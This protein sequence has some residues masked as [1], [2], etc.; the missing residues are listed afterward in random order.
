MR[1]LFKRKEVDHR[2]Q[3]RSKYNEKKYLEAEPHLLE[4]LESDPDDKW[5][6]DV[7][8]RLYYNTGRYVDSIITCKRL[9][10]IKE[11]DD[12]RKLIISA[13][14]RSEDWDVV[15]AETDAITWTKDDSVL[16]D[17]ILSDTPNMPWLEKFTER[18]YEEGC[19]DVPL[20][21]EL[22]SLKDKARYCHKSG[23]MANT[24]AFCDS[25]LELQESS[26]FATD[27]RLKAGMKIWEGEFFE[28]ELIKTIDNWPEQLGFRFMLIN[29]LLSGKNSPGE[30]LKVVSEAR[31]KWNDN[32]R[33]ICTEAICHSR[34][35]QHLQAQ[36]ICDEGMLLYPDD[37]EIL[38]ATAQVQ[39]GAGN[40]EKQL[41]Y[42]NSVLEKCSFEAIVSTS[43]EGEITPANL[44]CPSALNS[45]TETLVSIVMTTYK[46]DPLIKTAV[47]SILNQ[48]HTNLELIIV[49][50]C[51]PD[52]N[53]ENLKSLQKG[54][55]RII[56]HQMEENGGTYVA[57]NFGMTMA[58]GEY[59]GFMDSDDYCHPQRIEREV[60]VLKS[61]P[62]AKA[63]THDYF[64]IDENSNIEFR[65]KGALRM[66]CISLLISRDVVEKIGYFDSLRVGA[67]TEYIERIEAVFG[68]DAHIRDRIP[69]ML[70]TLH[71]SSLTGGG[72]FHISW[73]SVSGL[74]LSHHS[75]FR[76]WHEQIKSGEV[77]GFIPRKIRI[78]PYPVPEEMKSTHLHWNEGMPLFSE[79]IQKR[80]NS[81]WKEGKDM[82]QK[83]L[84]AKISGREHV[85]SLGFAVPDLHWSG[86]DISKIPSFD[87]LPPRFVLKPE[88]GWS[89]KNV[90]CL[91]RQA[92]GMINHL[93]GNIYSEEEVIETFSQDER[94]QQMKPKIMIEEFLI[95][96]EKQSSDNIPRDFKF[97]CFG[98]EIALL[99]VVL[100][101][102][103]V[104][105]SLNEW[106]YFDPQF[107]P[108]ESKIMKNSNLPERNIPKPDCWEEM[109]E[110]VSKIGSKLGIFMRIDMFA[111]EKGPVFGEFTP[112]PH[113]GKG[114]SEFADKYLGSFWNGE[115]GC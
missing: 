68:K 112:T 106:E 37:F 36:K 55:S 44:S 38:L 94:F 60:E 98:G 42:I 17:K 86:K 87:D 28:A 92:E 57:K 102:S 81:W 15:E 13:G 35:G 71:T 79:M 5:A 46:K 83:H 95:P 50:D 43:N 72:K 21:Y 52:D 67:D 10:L 2:S 53:F 91:E 31:L 115:E 69:S 8:S 25:I 78:R 74:R 73:R 33:L 45:E 6:L 113:G 32:L 75:S 29:F 93:E 105:T 77:D 109:V 63:V 82:W 89:A 16:I 80:Q 41:A 104:D 85:E 62:N 1:W 22:R 30:A 101:R 4:I 59:I 47:D 14:I 65:G 56:I 61:N 40:V 84:S 99:H 34:I 20:H 27:L 51:S 90:F 49:D 26:K 18:L 66:A 24:V 110:V 114:Y 7:L 70:M 39:K 100:R 76:A 19:L 64:R 9:L 48:T 96:E 3:A 111:T 108:I 11:S 97:Y 23:D 12:T 58:K 54:D 88:K 107:K 103:A